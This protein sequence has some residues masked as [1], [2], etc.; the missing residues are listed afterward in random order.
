[1]NFKGKSVLVTG[2]AGTVGQELV[3]QLLPRVKEIIIVD[4]NESEVFFMLEQF[5]GKIKGYV[6]D[7]SNRD[8][9]YRVMCGIDIVFHTAALKHVVLGE[10]SPDSIVQTNV[11]GIQNVIDAAL[12]NNV[13]RFIFT[14]S[15]KAVNPTNV[16]GTSKLLGERLVTATNSKKRGQRTIFCSTRF[17]N[18][19][20]SRGSVFPIFKRQIKAGG[21]ITITDERMTRFIMTIPEAVGLIIEAASIAEGGEV[22]VT[23]MPIMK[24]TD[25]AEVMREELAPKY[26]YRPDDI[27]MK[28]IGS[29]PGEKLYEE[30]MSL[31]EVDRSYE[32]DKFFCILPAFR[33]EYQTIEY[34][35]T[36]NARKVTDPYISDEEHA[37]DTN[38]IR[39]YLKKNGLLGD[40]E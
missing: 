33:S 18:V 22:F 10:R 31:E 17:G 27:A 7:I 20:G 8:F 26:G 2:G 12:D 36:K 34:T 16:M 25:L 30:L 6:G 23:K 3:R 4:N 9:M 1:M 40:T 35:N 19:I 11:V 15:D 28:V 39:W 14:S 13:E 5:N 32:F 24:I 38:Y 37:Q 21:P 29:K